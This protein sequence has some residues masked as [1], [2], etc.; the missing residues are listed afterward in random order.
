MGMSSWK[1][2]FVNFPDG[3]MK[4]GIEGKLPLACEVL[5]ALLFYIGVVLRYVWSVDRC[6]CRI[7][8][9]F[10]FWGLVFRLGV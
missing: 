3:T 5:G 1:T 9:I 2:F 6:L 10:W 4:L 8:G 7:W